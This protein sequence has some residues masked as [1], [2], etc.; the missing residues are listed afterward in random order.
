MKTNEIIINEGPLDYLKKVG[1]AVAS[2]VRSAAANADTRASADS[3]NAAAQEQ[4]AELKKWTDLTWQSFN[5]DLTN[6]KTAHGG[7]L[8]GADDSTTFNDYLVSWT[9]K[10]MKGQSTIPALQKPEIID[11][12]DTKTIYTYLSNRYAEHMPHTTPSAGAPT[13]RIGNGAAA[14]T[15]VGAAPAAAAPAAAAPAPFNPVEFTGKLKTSW[16]QF[17]ASGRP[18]PIELRKMIKQMWLDVGGVKAESRQPT[19]KKV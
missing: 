3:A 4:A 7:K 18:A 10:F 13:T 6:Y 1:S 2:G 8:P 11:P 19:K 9:D 15:S 16:D 12:S 14:K 5:R 17:V